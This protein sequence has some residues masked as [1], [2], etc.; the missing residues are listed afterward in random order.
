MYKCL[1]G[2][3]PLTLCKKFKQPSDIHSGKHEGPPTY[4]CLFFT[5]LQAKGRLVTEG[6]TL[7]CP[8]SQCK[9]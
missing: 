4:S 2:L 5:L 8:G 9:G 6:Q 7:E 3:A 1:H